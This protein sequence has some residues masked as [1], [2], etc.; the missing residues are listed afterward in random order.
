MTGIRCFVAVDI[1][2]EMREEIGRLQGQ[3]AIDGMRL[4]RPELVHVT[5]K[6]LGDHAEERVEEMNKGPG[7]DPCQAFSCSGRG[8]GRLF[9]ADP[10]VSY[11]S[12]WRADF[13][14]LYEKVE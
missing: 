4:V 2:A 7:K 14:E 5:L 6:F 1:P 9:R 12:A 11:G 8:H 13:E 3:I 10:F